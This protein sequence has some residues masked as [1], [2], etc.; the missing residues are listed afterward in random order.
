MKVTVLD[1]Y[2]GVVR[3]LACFAK[4]A[5]HV[6]TIHQAPAPDLESLVARLAD[7]QALLLIRERTAITRQLLERLPNLRLISLTGPVPHVDLAA[8]ADHGV[9]VCSRVVPARPSYATAELTWGLVLAAWRRIPQEMAHLQAGGWQS[10][11]AVGTT[12]RGKTLGIYGYGRIGSLVAGYGRAFGM[13]V[14]AWGRAGSRE[15]ALADG[16]EVAA[17]EEEFF[18][19]CDV[20]SLHM[21]LNDATRGIVRA[22][23]LAL[24]KPSALLVN[25]SRAGL[26]QLG[27]LAA[28]VSAGRPG[29]TAVD[30]FDEE[31]LFGSGD[32][33]LHLPN[34]V[35]T[36]HLGYVVREGLEGMLDTMIEQMLAFERGA[37]INVLQRPERRDETDNLQPTMMKRTP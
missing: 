28:A 34:V 30:V 18:S 37:P 12:L 19:S 14:V 31:P 16:F 9:T 32:Q 29:L 17:T 27:A 1:D 25:T 3:T 33:L 7:A 35:A 36:P 26:I 21:P 23:Q 22:D 4:L 8:C 24:M 20:L 6:V 11:Q 5:G 10:P 15:R 2:Q 13:K